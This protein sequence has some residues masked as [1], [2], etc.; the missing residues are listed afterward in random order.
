HALDPAAAGDGHAVPAALAVVGQRVAAVLEY[1]DRRLRVR[2]LG[3][4]HQEHVGPRAVQ[5]PGDLVQPGLQGVDV[6]GRD[7]HEPR[8]SR[9][10]PAEYGVVG[11]A[12]G[13]ALLTPA[14]ARPN[15]CARQ[16]GSRCAPF[17]PSSRSR[18]A[19]FPSPVRP[20]RPPAGPRTPP[21]GWPASTPTW[22]RWSRTGTCPASGWR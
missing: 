17:S 20:T 14:G 19:W 8:L 4:L 9:A 2:E 13:V 1:A 22:R 11:T 7:A 3:L 5:P 15:V 12:I 16:G 21:R 10:R 18:S 6:P